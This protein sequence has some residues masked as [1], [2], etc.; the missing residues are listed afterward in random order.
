MFALASDPSKPGT[1]ETLLT[2]GTR[3]CPL[4]GRFP[5]PVLDATVS[6]ALVFLP[7][8][9]LDGHHDTPLYGRSR[10]LGLAD[11]SPLATD[12]GAPANQSA[13]L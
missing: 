12:L 10:G 7:C 4:Q 9:P 2:G 5:G 3:T 6:S 11:T 13:A 8:A 1:G